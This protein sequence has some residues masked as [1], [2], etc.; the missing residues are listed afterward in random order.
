MPTLD[1]MRAIVVH[2]RKRPKYMGC[3]ADRSIIASTNFGTLLEN[4]CDIS[5]LPFARDYVT[6][7]R[8][9]KQKKQWSSQTHAEHNSLTLIMGAVGHDLHGALL[10][11]K[12]FFV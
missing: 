2:G 10:G 11:F 3:Q 5:L 8:M 6:V 4:R 12:L 7:Q 9:S 1:A